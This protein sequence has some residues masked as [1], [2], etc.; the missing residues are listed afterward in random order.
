MEN[1]RI[2][3]KNPDGG[4]SIVIPAPNCG[5]TLDEIIEKDVP[6]G[7][8]YR[9][10]DVSDIS[11]DRTFR[12]AWEYGENGVIKTSFK[13]AVEVTKERLRSERKPLLEEQDVAFQI[14]METGKNMDSVVSEKKRLRDI[15]LKADKAKTLDELKAITVKDK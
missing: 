9:I 8:D 11:T 2:L 1:V 13:K 5:L 10:V 7:V 12:N 14:A 6:N 4:V 3:Y 15:T